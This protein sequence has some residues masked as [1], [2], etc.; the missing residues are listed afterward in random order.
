[1]AMKNIGNLSNVRQKSQLSSKYKIFNYTQVKGSQ[2]TALV[3]GGFRFKPRQMSK[4]ASLY[5]NYNFNVVPVLSG[6]NELATPTLCSSR[7]KSLAEK[8]QAENKPLAIHCISG[9]FWTMVYIL[10]H[11]DRDW[12]EENV[13][14]ILFDSCP[15]LGDASGMGAFAAFFLKKHYLKPYLSPL[16]HPYLYYLGVTEEFRRDFDLKVFGERSVIPRNAHILFIQNENDF[17][18]NKEYLTKFISEV[19][20]NQSCTASVTVKEFKESKHTM[21]LAHHPEPYKEAVHDLLSKV[22]AWSN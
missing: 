20:A 17:V 14:T 16:C 6:L 12:R 22:P 1:M 15:V 11:M 13:K 9:A 4:H 19:K 3:L 7:G 21:S 2:S 18:V 8:L 10:E 5:G